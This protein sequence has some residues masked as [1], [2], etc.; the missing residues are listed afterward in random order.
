MSELSFALLE[1]GC[2]HISSFICIKAGSFISGKNLAFHS[3]LIVLLYP[4]F[5]PPT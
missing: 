5:N 2:S 1:K 4:E 3:L